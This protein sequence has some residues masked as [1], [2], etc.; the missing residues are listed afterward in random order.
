MLLFLALSRFSAADPIHWNANWNYQHS[1][2]DEQDSRWS[3]GETYGISLERNASRAMSLGAGLRYSQRRDSDEQWQGNLNPSLSWALRNDL[4]SLQLGGNESRSKRSGAVEAVNRA[5]SGSFSTAPAETWPQLH[6]NY[7]RS[8]NYDKASPPRQDSWSESYNGSLSYTWTNLE[9]FYSGRYARGQDESADTAHDGTSHLAKLEGSYSLWAQRL[10]VSFS[11]QYNENES[12]T[13]I[14]AAAGERVALP[15]PVSAQFYGF[16]ENPVYSE[17]DA[18]DALGDGREDVAAVEWNETEDMDL[19]LAARLDAQDLDQV[20]LVFLQQPDS[21][22]RQLLQAEVYT[23]S[24]NLDWVKSNMTHTLRWEE[25]AV[26]ERWHLFLELDQSVRSPYVKIVLQ[27]PAGLWDSVAISECIWSRVVVSNGEKVSSTSAFKRYKYQGNMR[28]RPLE[29]WY[30]TASYGYDLSVPGQGLET[31]E[32]QQTYGIQWFPGTNLSVQARYSEN[33]TIMEEQAT[34]T[35]RTWSVAAQ[36]DPL[37]TLATGFSFNCSENLLDAE[38]QS[39]IYTASSN[40]VAQLL[41]D[42]SASLNASWSRNKDLVNSS[43][44]TSTAYTLDTSAQLRPSLLLTLYVNHGATT[45]EAMRGEEDS[46]NLDCGM[47]L[48]Y[49]PSDVLQNN[50]N[51]SY[52]RNDDSVKVSSQVSLRLSNAVQANVS[53]A[54]TFADETGQHYTASLVWLATRRLNLRQNIQYSH[55]EVAQWS[56]SANCNYSF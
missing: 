35:G 20:E 40:L 24:N 52:D 53:A 16:D 18:A 2:G 44:T 1:G 5:L 49:R 7:S 34:E 56:Y 14:T 21:V 32:V 17:L 36:W 8:E 25:D 31:E 28:L 23:S 51:L 54:Y 33:E 37:R 55:V 41:P 13:D 9:A 50:N 19:S 6:L 38:V 3:L 12:T 45:M 47:S 11:T 22:F 42:W 10:Q 39:R 15:Q 48:N 27:E 26:F 46:S 30:I 4:F 43:E 29:K